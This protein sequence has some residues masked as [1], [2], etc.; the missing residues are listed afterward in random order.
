[1][2]IKHLN[3]KTDYTTDCQ[4]LVTPYK[5]IRTRV[6]RFPRAREQQLVWLSW[7]GR[8]GGRGRFP[9]PAEPGNQPGPGPAR[10]MGESGRPTAQALDR[11]IDPPGLLICVP[12]KAQLPWGVSPGKTQ[13]GLRIGR[14]LM[15]NEPAW[16]A[17]P[18]GAQA[19]RVWL[20]A[21]GRTVMRSLL[22]SALPAVSGLNGSH[23]F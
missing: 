17:R 5:Y 3:I 4:C 1:M 21:A 23:S 9:D 22:R 6:W 8:V 16:R 12:A 10:G 13:Q 14:I 19:G 20:R 7:G 15:G 2:Y 18:W 11:R